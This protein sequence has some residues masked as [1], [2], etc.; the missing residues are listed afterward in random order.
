[1]IRV[2]F[3]AGLSMCVL[4]DEALE[5]I[6]KQPDLMK[7]FENALTHAENAMAK[8]RAVVRDA[9]TVG[10]LKQ[11]LDGVTGGLELSLESLRA[12]GKTPRKMGRQ[13][14]KG[15]LKSRDLL[16]QLEQLVPAIS[17]DTRPPA[18]EAREVV[19]KIHQS[20]IEGVMSKK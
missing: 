20:Y 10:D 3:L 2:A 4:T 11:A 9:G 5:E 7:R 19:S 18:E 12:T 8:A 16:R 13:Y 1:M 14:K 17:L 15:E 6:R